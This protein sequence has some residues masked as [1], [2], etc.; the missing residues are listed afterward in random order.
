MEGVSPHGRWSL[1]SIL[2]QTIFYYS[3][4]ESIG[5][6]LHIP[7]VQTCLAMLGGSL[8]EGMCTQPPFKSSRTAFL[9]A[10]QL[11]ELLSARAAQICAYYGWVDGHTL[12]WLC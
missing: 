10:W 8:K 11:P 1:R 7:G 12:V 4:I 9:T 5:S 6:S 2:N 3:M